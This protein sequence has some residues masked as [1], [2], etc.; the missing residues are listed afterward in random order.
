MD[1]DM[2]GGDTGAP[3]PTGGIGM[4][5]QDVD[6]DFSEDDVEAVTDEDDE[7]K[8]LEEESHIGRSNKIFRNPMHPPSA[9]PPE[10]IDLTEDDDVIPVEEDEDGN[11][12]ETVEMD[13]DDDDDDDLPELMEVPPLSKKE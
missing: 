2:G 1:D 12:N 6:S 7:P 8:I 4:N 9:N 3:K 11:E 10:C 13:A 5:I